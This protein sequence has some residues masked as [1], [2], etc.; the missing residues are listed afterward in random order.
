MMAGRVKDL[1]SDDATPVLIQAHSL[2]DRPVVVNFDEKK[3]STLHKLI[4]AVMNSNVA[5]VVLEYECVCF[6]E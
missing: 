5:G 6:I 1:F 2:D 4:A 3:H